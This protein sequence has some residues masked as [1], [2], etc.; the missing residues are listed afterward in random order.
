MS[1]D[2]YGL[3]LSAVKYL[4]SL[5]LPGRKNTQVNLAA[6]IGRDKVALNAS[7]NRRINTVTK[8]EIRFSPEAQEA[9]AKYYG[10]TVADMIGIGARIEKGETLNFVLRESEKGEIST[11]DMD[12][13]T[14]HRISSQ[15]SVIIIG[16]PLLNPYPQDK[17]LTAFLPREVHRALKM[18]AARRDVPMVQIV[19]EAL[20]SEL[21]ANDSQRYPELDYL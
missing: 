11:I 18:E 21:R 14:R 19:V 9:I 5:K 4:L 13:P 7:L 8:T 10:L 3:F 16:R 20:I 17:K 2:D 6:G 1:D 15:S 12:N